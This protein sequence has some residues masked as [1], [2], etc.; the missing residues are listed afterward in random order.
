ME[1]SGSF[2]GRKIPGTNSIQCLNIK[3]AGEGSNIVQIKYGP[4]GTVPLEVF[5]GAVYLYSYKCESLSSH[6]EDCSTCHY[7]NQSLGYE[8]QWCQTTGCVDIDNDQCRQAE[9]CGRPVVTKISPPD[10]PPQGG[11]VVIIEG[12]NFGI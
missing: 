3:T 9:T 7:L 11:T 1:G 10:G 8:C 5:D 2:S 6:K 4:R 12:F